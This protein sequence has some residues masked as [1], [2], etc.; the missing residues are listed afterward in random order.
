VKIQTYRPIFLRIS[1]AVEEL[2]HLYGRGKFKTVNFKRN[3]ESSFT[4]YVPTTQRT[5]FEEKRRFRCIE[6]ADGKT[7]VVAL[8]RRRVIA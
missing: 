5:G 6:R 2:N 1:D 7:V 3:G 4:R 8:G